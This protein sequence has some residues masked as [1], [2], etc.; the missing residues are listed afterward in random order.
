MFSAH[1]SSNQKRTESWRDISS[2]GWPLF[3]EKVVLIRLPDRFSGKGPEENT[4]CHLLDYLKSV[5]NTTEI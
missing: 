3:K 2:S 5:V 1:P 4:L